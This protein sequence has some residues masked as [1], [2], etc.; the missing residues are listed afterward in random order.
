MAAVEVVIWV[1]PWGMTSEGRYGRMCKT[2][3][4]GN[5]CALHA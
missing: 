3:M 1:A 4:A 2:P 5:K